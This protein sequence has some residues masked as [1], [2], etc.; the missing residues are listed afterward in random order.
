VATT[1]KALLASDENW[2]VWTDWYEARLRGGRANEALELA[3]VQITDEIWQQGPKAVNAYIKN[4]IAQYEGMSSPKKPESEIEFDNREDVQRWLQ[5]K[6]A[7]VVLLMAARAALRALPALVL[8]LRPESMGAAARI[9]SRLA[10]FRAL[11]VAWAAASYKAD[12]PKLRAEAELAIAAPFPAEAASMAALSAARGVRDDPPQQLFH[13]T[14]AI[15]AAI[16]AADDFIRSLTLIGSAGESGGGSILTVAADD[17]RIIERGIKTETVATH[18]LWPGGYPRWVRTAWNQLSNALLDADPSWEVWTRWYEAR[19]N[20]GPA[21]QA[22]E[23]ARATIPDEIWQQG[24]KVVNAHIKELIEEFDRQEKEIAESAW[25]DR[26]EGKLFSQRPAAYRFAVQAGRIEAMVQ[27]EAPPDE[28]IAADIY[29]GLKA[30]AE[31][32][33]ERLKH[34]NSAVVSFKPLNGYW[35]AW[36]KI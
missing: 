2:E 18:P 13:A 12:K 19:L 21:N 34:S 10:V 33:L 7:D 5:G 20:G 17:A 11:A 9:E 16:E 15:G 22:L 35:I 30:K 32:L 23:I 4:L 1:K 31:E 26:D 3:R 27:R 8:G 36:V 14:D 29:A 6:P 25:E 24:P 28:T